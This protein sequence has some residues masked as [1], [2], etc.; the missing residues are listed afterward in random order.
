VTATAGKPGY[1]PIVGVGTPYAQNFLG[2]PTIPLA[3]NPQTVS[4]P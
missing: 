1:D 3:G 2:V 4:N